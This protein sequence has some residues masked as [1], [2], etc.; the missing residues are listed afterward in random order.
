MSRRAKYA[1]VFINNLRFLTGSEVTYP[2]LVP[3]MMAKELDVAQVPHLLTLVR[4]PVTNQRLGRFTLS[5]LC[6]WLYSYM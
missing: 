6:H 2:T 1:S 4:K 3:H 5:L